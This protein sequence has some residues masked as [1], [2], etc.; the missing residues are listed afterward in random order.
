LSV[1]S[2]AEV[3]ALT[4]DEVFQDHNGNGT[5]EPA[6]DVIGP[7]P[8]AA[9][10]DEGCGRMAFLADNA[11]QVGYEDNAQMLWT[12]LRWAS[13]GQSCPVHSVMLPLVLR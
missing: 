13:Q 3:L 7:F 9:A 10:Y 5:Y 4:P 8:I 11:F 12:L 2:P 1:G 6:E